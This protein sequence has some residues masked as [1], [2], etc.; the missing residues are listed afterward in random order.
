MIRSWVKLL[1]F[2][3]VE[4]LIKKIVPYYMKISINYHTKSG[5]AWNIKDNLY[6]FEVDK[7]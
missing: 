3:I 6:L 5:K 7:I 4:L 1:P 2:W